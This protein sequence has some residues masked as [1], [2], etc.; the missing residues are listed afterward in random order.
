MIA[1]SKECGK[2]WKGGKRD[3]SRNSEGALQKFEPGGAQ[4]PIEDRNEYERR[5]NALPPDQDQ[6][7]QETTRLADLCQYFSLQKIDVPSEIAERVAGLSRL[8][9]PERIRALIDVNRALME[10]LNDVGQDP[11]IRQ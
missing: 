3:H 1:I 9:T 4:G 7:A 6:L 11:G 5:L 10:Y 2:V 8:A